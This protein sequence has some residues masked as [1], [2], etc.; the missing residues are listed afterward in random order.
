MSCILKEVGTSA[1]V[2]V[3]PAVWA[4]GDV[5]AGCWGLQV[6][7]L[8]ELGPDAH[9]IIVGRTVMGGSIVPTRLSCA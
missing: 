3:D 9:V 1:R 7:D 4:V 5:C 8:V 6:S 2:A